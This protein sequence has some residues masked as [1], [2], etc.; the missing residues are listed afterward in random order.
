MPR[1]QQVGRTGNLEP[2]EGQSVRMR[3]QICCKIT[4]VLCMDRRNL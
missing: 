4:D 3:L 2:K 1:V